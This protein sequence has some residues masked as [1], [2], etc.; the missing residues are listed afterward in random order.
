[1]NKLYSE[2]ENGIDAYTKNAITDNEFRAELYQLVE[3]VACEF[4]DG[5]KDY[6]LENGQR[7]CFDERTTKELFTHFIQ[8]IYNQ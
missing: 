3:D 6:E 2:I 1:M 5:I 8:K 4:L 7:I